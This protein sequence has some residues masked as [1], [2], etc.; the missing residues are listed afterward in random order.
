MNT[1][2]N[3]L[4]ELLNT[5]S[6]ELRAANQKRKPASGLLGIGPGPGDDPCHERL[7]QAVE[8]LMGDMIQDSAGASETGP[9]VSALLRAESDGCWPESARLMLLAIQRHAIPL[10]PVL[11]RNTRGELYVW[12]EKR[13]PR[14]RRFPLQKQ[15]L[16]AL[17]NE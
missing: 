16:T 10:I 11:E 9:V 1:Y 14:S 3:R 5:Y 15:I 2:L 13:H 8:A 12:Y 6:D 4:Q 7:D 17:K